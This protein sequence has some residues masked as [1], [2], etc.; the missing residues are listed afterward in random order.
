MDGGDTDDWSC[1]YWT[2]SSNNGEERSSTNTT[3]TFSGNNNPKE[4]IIRENNKRII[5]LPA[6]VGVVLVPWG[7]YEQFYDDYK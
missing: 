2:G 7:Q 1:E 3:N 6:T 4:E 5:P